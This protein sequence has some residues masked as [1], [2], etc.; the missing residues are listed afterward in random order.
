MRGDLCSIGARA[1]T[2]KPPRRAPASS[3]V[4]MGCDGGVVFADLATQLPV[5]SEFAQRS[6]QSPIVPSEQSFQ[7][8]AYEF[9]G[10]ALVAGDDRQTRCAG[11]EGGDT[12]GFPHRGLH[13]GIG[14]CEMRSDPGMGQATG[15][16]YG[17]TQIVPVD[18]PFDPPGLG[19]IADDGRVDTSTCGLVCLRDDV[20]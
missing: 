6:H 12:E 7:F 5:G 1:T 18:E 10:A 15:E 13:E 2:G 14:P 19:A 16:R 4:L 8:V 3:P 17:R 9:P 11:L 20:H